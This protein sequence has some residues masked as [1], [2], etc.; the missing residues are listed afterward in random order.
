MTI[1]TGAASRDP[2]T[3]SLGPPATEAGPAARRAL[4]ACALGW[5]FDG[6]E[7]YALFLVGSVAIRDLVAPGELAQ[8]PLYFGGLVAMTLLGWATGGV[9]FG[10]F[11]DYLGRRRTLMLSILLYAGFTGLSAVAQSYWMLL[12]FRFFTG[13]GL[14]GEFAPGT[15]LVSELWTPG[16]R[17]RAA[18]VLA[19][20]FGFG[21]LLA[22]G[23]WLLVGGL[24]PG[25]WRIM[26]VI[27]VLPAL[28]ILWLRRSV[29]DPA[30]WLEADQRRRAARQ[31]AGA[32]RP[33]SEDE[34]HLTRFTIAGLF[35]TPELRRRTLL[36]LVMSLATVVGYWCVSTWV[37]QYGGQV[38]ARAGYA[39][40]G[41]DALAGLM[42]SVGGIAGYLTLGLLGDLWG[43]K[44][45]IALFFAG[46]A[47]VAPAPFLID[48]DVA[49]FMAATAIN[50]FFT[51]GQFAWMT[52]YLPEVYP[53]WVRATGT[54]VIF[55]SARYLAAIGPLVAGW[56]VISLGGIAHVAAL[57]S[58]IYLLGLVATPFAAP[59]T[60]G[61][62]LPP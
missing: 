53:T 6:Y 40:G 2:S 12:A 59:E 1:S 32:G 4:L 18:G 34:R 38:A 60:R 14:G 9:S 20:A 45:T 51:L 56:V 61:Q 50:G 21:C 43:R 41:W 35:A 10:V 30:I 47:V 28:L 13:L 44:P 39:A 33:L 52:V 7:T 15:T 48:H 55:N 37:P 16:R 26:F 27:G 22:S 8:L 24:G 3:S 25:A 58:V 19:S 62:P 36:L 11:A 49:L 54:A 42:Y 23:V 17:G 29:K 5:L 46:S 31:A 57:M